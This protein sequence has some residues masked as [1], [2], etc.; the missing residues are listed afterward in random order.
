MIPGSLTNVAMQKLAEYLGMVLEGR[1]RQA[2][3]KDGLWLDIVEYGV[4]LDE[5][6]DKFKSSVESTE[7]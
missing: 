3:F 4:L 2:A 6:L 7:D 5:Y 1:R